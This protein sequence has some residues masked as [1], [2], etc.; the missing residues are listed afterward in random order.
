M[1]HQ[2]RMSRLQ[3]VVATV[4]QVASA[5]SLATTGLRSRVARRHLPLL[6]LRIIPLGLALLAYARALPAP[7]T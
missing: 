4:L 1:Y 7:G 6:A 5:T 3:R 2:A